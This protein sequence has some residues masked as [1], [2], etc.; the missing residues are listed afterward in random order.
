[1]L[2]ESSLLLS[3][4]RRA[5]RALGLSLAL[6][7][8]AVFLA[9]PGA[10]LARSKPAPAKDSKAAPAAEAEPAADAKGKKGG[11]A[12]KASDKA[13]AGG[14]SG[15]PEQLGA[16]GEWGAFL[17]QGG[18]DKTC[19]ALGQPK[20]RQPKAK[21]KDTSAYIFISTRPGENVR[22]EVAINL[23]YGTKDGSAA[24]AEIDGDGWE[25]V[26]KG[27]NAWVKE[28]AREKE[29]VGA[30]RGG[31]KLVVKASSSKGTSTTDTYALKGLSDALA[32]VAQECK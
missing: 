31:S 3:V 32:R 6:G 19:Y 4:S 28:Q 16:Y 24:T 23:G 8:S 29:F 15:K 17:A 26:T 21:L 20:D 11:K 14:G 18:K 25:L 30:L 10:A 12:E 1:M 5:P 22:N 13:D 27:T 9:A 2:N 7:L